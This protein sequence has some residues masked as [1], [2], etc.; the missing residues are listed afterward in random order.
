M[1]LSRLA[2]ITVS[3]VCAACIA[4]VRADCPELNR[5]PAN[6]SD[7]QL[8]ISGGAAPSGARAADDFNAP[9]GNGNVYNVRTLKA[10]MIANYTMNATNV[11]FTIYTD[12]TAG[13]NPPRPHP[14]TQIAPPNSLTTT[15]RDLGAYGAS[16]PDGRPL[17]IYEITWAIPT[18]FMQLSAGAWYWLAPHGIAVNSGPTFYDVAYVALGAA[19]TNVREPINASTGPVFTTWSNTATGCC[20]GG[21]YDLGIFVDLQQVGRPRADFTCDFILSVTDIFTFMNIWFAGSPS[22]DFNGVNGLTVLDLFDYLNAWF[23]GV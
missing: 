9:I 5:L 8:S 13:T 16:G 10:V 21:P 11:G 17:R 20:L 4:P 12:T 19:G 23:A 7:G 2:W 6:T 3:L 15:V 14:G 1:N 22:G 18:G